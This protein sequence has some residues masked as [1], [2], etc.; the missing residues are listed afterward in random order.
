MRLLIAGCTGPDHHTLKGYIRSPIA[1][2]KGS[3]NKTPTSV[4]IGAMAHYIT[5]KH[6]I[7]QAWCIG[8]ETTPE[9]R[10]MRHES[11]AHDGIRP[12]QSPLA[13]QECFLRHEKQEE[14]G[15]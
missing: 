14:K 5:D 8:N 15:S 4:E 6:K 11:P 3:V 13:G 1:G 9:D 10:Q 7:H 2:P 12:C